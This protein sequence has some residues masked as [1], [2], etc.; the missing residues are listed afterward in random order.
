MDAVKFDARKAS[1]VEWP[2]VLAWGCWMVAVCAVK[3]G[4]IDSCKLHAD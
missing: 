1:M 2:N 4:T 3:D